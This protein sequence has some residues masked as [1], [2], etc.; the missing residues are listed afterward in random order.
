MLGDVTAR[1]LALTTERLRLVPFTAG[2]LD[3]LIDKDRARLEALTGVR[4]PEPLLAPPL[5]EDALPSLR[6]AVR[7]AAGEPGWGPWLASARATSEAIG[8]VGLGRPDQRGR[9]VLGYAIYPK[10]E[11]RGYATEAT[12]ALITW[13]LDQV[14]VAAVRATIPPWHT[15]SLRVALKA[16][17][18]QVGTARDE[19]VGDVLAFEAQRGVM[20]RTDAAKS[21]H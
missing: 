5:M 13:S 4:F 8:C 1:L 16:G 10:F 15:P 21:A 12:R 20:A 11:G 19:E 2:A 14:G 3:V 6:E 17:M 9:V 18:Q 7:T